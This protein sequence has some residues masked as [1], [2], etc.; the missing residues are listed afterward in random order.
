MVSEGASLIIHLL[1]EMLVAVPTQAVIPALVL[2]FP[3]VIKILITAKNQV[4]TKER[5]CK[6]AAIAVARCNL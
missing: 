6:V 4:S 3:A 1:Q 2:L 5:A